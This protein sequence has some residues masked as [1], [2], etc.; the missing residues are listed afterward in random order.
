MYPQN[1]VVG[2]FCIQIGAIP[3]QDSQLHW[4]Q[5]LSTHQGAVTSLISVGPH[6]HATQRS[7]PT[8]HVTNEGALK[9]C[10]LVS[11][12]NGRDPSATIEK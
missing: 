3:L 6:C 11:L 8:Y 7:I 2:H 12:Q 9:E 4:L 5:I 1:S 10:S